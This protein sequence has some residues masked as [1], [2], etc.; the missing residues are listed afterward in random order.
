MEKNSNILTVLKCQDCNGLFF[1]PKYGCPNCSSKR[2]KEVEL[3]GKGKL[4][5]YTTI[6][7]PPLGFEDQVPYHV[8]VI[9]LPEGINLPARLVLKEDEE[10]EIEGEVYFHKKEE[11]ACLFRLTT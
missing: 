1:P 3:S 5:T 4:M 9:E 11:G 8:A 10:P 2:L 7:V 6:R